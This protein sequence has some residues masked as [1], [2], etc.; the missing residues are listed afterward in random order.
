MPAPTPD[1]PLYN[2]PLPDIE[3]WLRS[4]GATQDQ[5]AIHC[6]QLAGENWQAQLCLEV[7]EIAISY[8]SATPADQVNRVFKY[9][10]SRQD[11]EAAIL[12]GP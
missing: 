1:T 10:L 9:S 7:E 11:I 8:A 5:A 12:A 4:I 6:W 3:A 2:Y